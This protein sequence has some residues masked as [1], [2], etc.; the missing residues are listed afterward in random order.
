MSQ[1]QCPLYHLLSRTQMANWPL[2]CWPIRYFT[3]LAL[4]QRSKSRNPFKRS[5]QNSSQN[6]PLNHQTMSLLVMLTQEGHTQEPEGVVGGG[7]RAKVVLRLSTQI[8]KPLKPSNLWLDPIGSPSMQVLSS[9]KAS[10]QNASLTW[11]E[12]TPLTSPPM[13]FSSTNSEFSKAICGGQ[14]T[15]V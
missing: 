6:Q 9:F 5:P 12:S 14:W 3:F 4:L 15:L 7:N 1:A 8:L 13:C 11:M 10:A 2:N